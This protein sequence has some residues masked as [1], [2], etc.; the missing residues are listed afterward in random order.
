MASHTMEN[1]L[2]L[3]PGILKRAFRELD[4]LGIYQPLVVLIVAR[5]LTRTLESR[6]YSCN[7][8]PLGLFLITIS[9][10]YCKQ[11]Q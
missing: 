3:L 9:R 1:Y 10:A 4:F 8:N 2:R 5:A 11:Y 6:R 7:C